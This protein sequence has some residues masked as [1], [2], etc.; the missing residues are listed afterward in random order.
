M[1]SDFE[2]WFIEE[3]QISDTWWW[4]NDI[5]A[6]LDCGVNA[7][8]CLELVSCSEKDEFHFSGLVSIG[9]PASMCGFH[10]IHFV[11]FLESLFYL[12]QL[13]VWNVDSSVGHLHMSS[14]RCCVC[15]R[16]CPVVTY[17]MWKELDLALSLG[18]L[19]ML[20]W[21]WVT[22]LVVGLDLGCQL[23]LFWLFWWAIVQSIR[24]LFL[25][26]QI[27]TWVCLPTG[28]SSPCQ[29]LH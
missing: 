1:S 5:I 23:L 22:V 10:L 20:G 9:W 17:I 21:C 16:Y 14:I 7:V 19:L 28:Y 4:W 2:E 25:Q 11:G 29:M 27:C 6:N 8:Y 15:C 18:I 13:I 26:F 12:L 3:T 24:V